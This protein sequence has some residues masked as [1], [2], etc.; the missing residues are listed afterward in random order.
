[1]TYNFSAGPST[2]PPQ[3]L[4][5]ARDELIDYRGTGMSL[6]EMSH[7]GPEYT[8]VHE[9][10]LS[11]AAEVFGAPEDMAV[12]FL[13]GG[14]T[15]QFSMVPMNLLSPGRPAGYVASGSW[16]SKAIADAQSYG[17]AYLAWDGEPDGFTRM[18]RAG[19]IQV[20]DGSRYLHVTS[21]ETIGGIQMHDW[22]EDA[23][24]PLVADMSSD[25]MSRPIPWDRFDLVYGGA[26]KNLGPAGLTIVYIRQEL[27]ES[28]NRNHG[29]YLR[30]DVHHKGG[31]M[32][33]TPP[34][35]AVWLMGKTLRWVLGQGGL[36]A[37]EA[38]AR[39]KA[40]L[41]YDT[42]DA[43]DGFYASPVA[44]DSRSLMNVV[45]R[46][47]SEVLEKAFLTEAAEAGLSGL[48]GHRDVGGMRASLYNAMSTEGVGALTSFMKAF[49]DDRG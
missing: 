45:F 2:L 5:E 40:G 33:N 31:S 29:A 24:V 39:A 4:E 20:R 32:Y 28:L 26:Q 36:G 18:P 3:V 43:S 21:N 11:L 27:L 8:A 35:F 9:E 42:I 1:M 47:P 38:S 10:A 34:V 25:I 16:A 48:K 49:R 15:L 23:G 17:D 46:L 12:L 22:P 44:E 19:E 7:R 41:L 13:Q 14:A 30:Y 6:V 37:I